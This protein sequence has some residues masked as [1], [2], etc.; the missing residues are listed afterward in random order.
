[1]KAKIFLCSLAIIFSGVLM[2]SSSAVAVKWNPGCVA[3]AKTV[4]IECVNACVEE[5]QVDKDSCRNVN[6]EDAELCRATY[7]LCVDPYLDQLANCKV[8]CQSDLAIAKDN[9]RIALPGGGQALD[10]CIDQ[11]QVE[12]FKCRDDCR[13]AVHPTLTTCRLAFKACIRACPPPAP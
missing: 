4:K 9:C 7:D 8:D 6:H 3:G 12:A 1:M 11:A 13:E 2:F 10:S 5:F